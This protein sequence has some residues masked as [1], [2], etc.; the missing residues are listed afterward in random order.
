MPEKER[1]EVIKALR[2]VDKVILSKHKSGSKD[3]SVSGELITLRPDVFANGGDR[4]KKDAANPASPLYRD[5]N[6]CKELGIK[7]VFSVGKGGKIQSSS[8]LLRKYVDG[9]GK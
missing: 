9:A 7:M 4:N 6:T 1:M 5:I 8:W 2:A 3:M